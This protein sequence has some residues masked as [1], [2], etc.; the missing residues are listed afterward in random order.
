MN[1]YQAN[2]AIIAQ[3]RRTVELHKLSAGAKAVVKSFDS[4]NVNHL[5]AHAK[6]VGSYGKKA[7]YQIDM[8]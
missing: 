3:H 5:I 8:K 4:K 7:C 2:L 1:D 6:A